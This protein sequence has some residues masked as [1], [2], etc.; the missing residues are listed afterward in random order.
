RDDKKHDTLTIQQI[1]ELSSNIGIGKL[2]Q[3]LGGEKLKETLR[4]FGFGQKLRVDLP[5]EAS[6]GIGDPGVWSEYNIAA[7]SIGHSIST[8]P[9]QLAAAVG[10][11]ANGG[12]LYRPHVIKGI[13]DSDNRTIKYTDNELIGRVMNDDNSE[14]LRSFLEGVVE[15]GTATPVQSSMISIAGKTGTAEIP[16]PENGGYLRNKFNAS[17]V[18]Y[19]PADKPRIAGVVILHQPEPVHYGGHTAGPAFKRMA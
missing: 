17:F 10:A 12:E 7:L 9:I 3:R 19:F 15:R 2:T 16:D 11:V 14:I 5:G 13:I 18:G 8:T 4:R 1:M 6:G